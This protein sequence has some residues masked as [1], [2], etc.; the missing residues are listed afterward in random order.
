LELVVSFTI[1]LNNTT[2]QKEK[3]SRKAQK[4]DAILTDSTTQQ[5]NKLKTQQLCAVPIII[6]ILFPYLHSQQ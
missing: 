6:V 2:T 1:E 5:T 3:G 4:N